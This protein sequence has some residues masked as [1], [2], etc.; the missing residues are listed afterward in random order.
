[1]NTINKRIAYLFNLYY[2]KQATAEEQQELFQLLKDHPVDDQELIGLMAKEW[3]GL[4]PAE[5]L[6]DEEKSKAIL[7]NIL[8]TPKAQD[9]PIAVKPKY[10]S[11]R[12]KIAATIIVTLSIGTYFLIRKTKPENYTLAKTH[13]ANDALPGENKAILTLANGTTVIL[14]DKQNGVIAKQGNTIVI[15]NKQGQ[16]GYKAA[17]NIEQDTAVG[18]N[19]ISTPKGYQYNIVLADGSKV[20][21]NAA[22]SLKF[23]T[24]FKGAER[25]VEITGEAYFEVTKNPAM[26]FIVK[27]N[28]QEVKVLG[29]HFCIM[30]YDDE[31]VV[32]T[33]LL[34]GSIRLTSQKSTHVLIPGNQAVLS[35]HGNVNIVEAADM[36]E[37]IAW[38]NGFF[39]FKDE[40][41]EGI[42]RQAAR[43]YDL[44]VSYQGKIPV[45]QF[46]GKIPRNVKLSEMLGM[47]K[48]A[49]IN[50]NIEGQHITITDK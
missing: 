26:P 13:M 45:R 10:L 16:V 44:D 41:I 8:R 17:D 46:T 37:A 11:T 19:T 25:N 49:G 50:F 35:A 23:P 38:K 21:L 12:F 40:N 15:K 27:T 34:E 36:D 3:N 29:T 30:A 43:W 28:S 18:Y 4:N 7:N 47:F 48:Y 33:S 14:D 31:S 39:Q 32:K 5:N 1:M 2:T 24:R 42:M 22:S 6:F 9:A 20:W